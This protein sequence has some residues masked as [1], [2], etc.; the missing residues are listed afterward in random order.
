MGIPDFG[1]LSL[2]NSSLYAD[3]NTITYAQAGNAGLKWETST[4]SDAGI[5]IGFLKD[6]FQLEGSYFNNN[7]NGLVLNSP[8]APSKGIPN[9]AI[10]VNIGSM[11]NKGIELSLQSTN[12]DKP[13]FSWS[14]NANFT[15]IK[16]EVTALAEGNAAIVGST[17]TLEKANITQVGYS[18]GCIYAV[19]TDG[20]NPDNGQ[21]IFINKD[22]LKVQY[23]HVV[24]AGQSRWTFMDGTP[25]PAITGSDAVVVG[26]ALPKWFGGFNN[27]FK[28]KNL[29]DL[30]IGI[31]FSGG[32]YIYNGSR[33]GMLDQRFWNNSVEILDHWTTPG[34]KTDI[35]RVVWNDNVSNGSSFPISENVEKGDF[36]KLKNI[37]LGYTFAEKV[38]GKSGIKSLRVYAQVT[39][40]YTLT[41]YSGSDPEVSTNGNSNLS[42][43]IDR[44]SVPQATTYTFGLNVSL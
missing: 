9:N 14:S 26:N 28:Y 29:I 34:Q 6:R 23:N 38:F 18:L 20:V 41:K 32:N 16:N 4:K 42:P 33:A 35:P 19:K 44:N 36:V 12:I 7:I 10:L 30:N 17:S 2:Y 27:K 5:V 24:P 43:G 25:A 40:I 13:K 1:S 22:G 21:R 37:S 31:T 39:N 15:S 11:Y 8:Q 3:V